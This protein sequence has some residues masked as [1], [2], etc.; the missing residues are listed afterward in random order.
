M[1]RVGREQGGEP[2]RPAATGPAVRLSRSALVSEAGERGGG[3]G[4][5]VGTIDIVAAVGIVIVVVV[6]VVC[7]W[8]IRWDGFAGRYCGMV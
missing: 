8:R 2:V 4:A 7:R 1:C 3:G 5:C 6:V